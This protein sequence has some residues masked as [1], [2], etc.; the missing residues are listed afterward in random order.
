MQ[1]AF[2]DN[3]RQCLNMRYSDHIVRMCPSFSK[4]VFVAFE[5]QGLEKRVLAYDNGERGR[6]RDDIKH[7][8]RDR[9]RGTVIM[10]IMAQHTDMNMAP[11]F[12]LNRVP[13]ATIHI[14]PSLSQ[15]R[16]YKQAAK[17]TFSKTRYSHG[18]YLRHYHSRATINTQKNSHFRRQGTQTAAE[19]FYSSPLK[20]Q[21][22]CLSHPADA[23]SS[24]G[25]DID[26]ITRFWC[27]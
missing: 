12:L 19:H 5:H 14:S 15:P 25:K 20:F 24:P 7:A 26:F 6:G 11:M 3:H 16:D 13:T 9:L 10:A 22:Q 21:R 2:R 17:F 27:Q 23:G 8:R 18:T 1:Q 4:N